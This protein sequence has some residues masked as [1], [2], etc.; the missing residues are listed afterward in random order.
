M[1]DSAFMKGR[2]HWL[3]NRGKK[4]KKER[5]SLERGGICFEWAGS[6]FF[7]CFSLSLS[8]YIYIYIYIYVFFFCLFYVFVNSFKFLKAT[9]DNDGFCCC[10]RRC[11]CC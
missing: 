8:L 6:L 7:V 1:K 11:C 5:T 10:C 2:L 4:K 9:A 3:L